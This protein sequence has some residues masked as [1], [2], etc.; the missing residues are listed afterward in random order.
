MSASVQKNSLTVIGIHKAP[1]NLSKREFD[2]KAR[3]FCDS[4]VAL[5]VVK[6]NFLSFDVIFQNSVLD[7]HMKELGWGEPQP[8]VIHIVELETV[9]K[10]TEFLQDAAFQKLM[11]N[12]DD[13][14]LPSVSITFSAD[15][16]TRIDVPRSEHGSTATERALW[17]GIYSGPGPAL[18]PHITQFQE[19]VSATMDEY[20]ALPVSQKNMLSHKVLTAN[21]SA[22]ATLQAHGYPNAEPA[23][24][25]M[26]EM[27]NWDRAIEICEDAEIKRVTEKANQGFGLL[28][29]A[30]CFGADVVSKIKKV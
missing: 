1:E 20:V 19:N 16:V 9:E 6:K 12:T 3:A 27:E 13:F 26:V 22:E 24:V 11:T 28:V 2:A 10:F 23:V 8:C 7:E 29:G 30:I 14:A 17:V 21:D 5:P 4:L 15:A 25:V 18:S